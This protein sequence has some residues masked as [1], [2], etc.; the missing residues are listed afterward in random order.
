[1][2][3][4]FAIYD[5]DIQGENVRHDWIA[6]GILIDAPGWQFTENYTG[7]IISSQTNQGWAPTKTTGQIITDSFGNKIPE[8]IPVPGWHANVR[9]VGYVAEAMTANL[10]QTDENGNLLPLWE[11]TWAEYIF[12]LVE[13]DLDPITNFP[14]GFRNSVSGVKYCDPVLFKS[15]TNVIA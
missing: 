10:P 15:P 4:D 1:M 2:Q 12:Q 3:I 7:I 9:V 13:V 11:R 14:S 6:A 5:S 8:I